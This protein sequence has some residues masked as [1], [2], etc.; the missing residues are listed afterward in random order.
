MKSEFMTVL[1][2]I[3]LMVLI[4]VLGFFGVIAYQEIFGETGN[5]EVKS[6]VSTYN[7]T[8]DSSDNLKEQN[9]VIKENWKDKLSQLISSI[10]NSE[11]EPP[12][13]EYSEVKVDKYFYNQLNDYSKIIYRAFESNKEQMKTGTAQI[14]LGSTFTEVLNQENGDKKLGEYYQ[15]AVETYLYDNPDVFYISANKLY[16]NIETTTRKRS[17][18]YNVFINNGEQPNYFTDDFSSESEVREDITKVEQIKNQIIA[19]K[20]NNIYYNIKM[21]H[22]YLIDTIEY[23]TTVSKKGIYNIYGALVEREGVCEAYAKAF[24]YLAD[25]IGIPCVMVIGQGTNSDGKTENHAWNYVEIDKKWYAVDCTWDDP[26]IIGNGKIGSD[27]RYRYFLRG[28]N[29][30]NKDHEV[31]G[32]FTDDGNTYTYP[33]LEYSDYR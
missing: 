14:D 9:K 7:E 20:T 29:T 17:T 25:E 13:A 30:M 26:V 18:T 3:L 8:V 23:D 27:V 19:A 31:S 10:T 28:S 4:V 2:T 5:T 15:S 6:Y 24:K 22:D 11:E 32:Q 33:T 16:I 1:L 21:I 12:K